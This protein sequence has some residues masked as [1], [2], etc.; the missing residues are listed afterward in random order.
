VNNIRNQQ[1]IYFHDKFEKHLAIESNSSDNLHP[2]TN[3]QLWI[4]FLVDAREW[5][6]SFTC[7]SLLPV[8][9]TE[10][11]ILFNQRY[12]EIIDEALTPLWARFHFHLSLTRESVVFTSSDTNLQSSDS[13]L[14]SSD[15]NLQSSVPLPSHT[16]EQLLW[17]FQYARNYI[18]MVI[19]LSDEINVS[20]FLQ[21]LHPNDYK[22]VA[23]KYIIEKSIRI[24]RAHI[25][26][27]FV[28]YFSK[29]TDEFIKIFVEQIFNLDSYLNTWESYQTINICRV[30][31][32][33]KPFHSRWLLIERTQWI[34]LL[35]PYFKNIKDTY[36]FEFGVDL[37]VLDITP[38][39]RDMSNITTT[40]NESTNKTAGVTELKCYKGIYHTM[41]FFILATQRY[42]YLPKESQDIVSAIILEP[43]L[44]LCV[45]M[46]LFKTKIDPSLYAISNK[47]SYSLSELA[48]SEMINKYKRN[49]TYPMELQNFLSSVQYVQKC[50][51]HAS[52]PSLFISNRDRYEDTWKIL[53]EWI[54]KRAIFDHEYRP[55]GLFSP[56]K[57]LQAS[58]DTITW[59]DYFESKSS[60]VI[61]SLLKKN[62]G[63]LKDND[64]HG[65][66]HHHVH[67]LMGDN[68]ELARAQMLTLSRV[69]EKQFQNNVLKL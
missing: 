9:L 49:R 10:S 59:K 61:S 5:L 60:S 20:D 30:L 23:R 4:N 11:K 52:Y 21:K 57:L 65:S 47:S 55:N 36:S 53:V 66:S 44:S 6:L 12:E 37:N 58:L 14:Q 22:K 31:Y 51:K 48:S 8:V 45:G 54:P 62:K 7:I 3:L 29:F 27:V 50:L 25:A 33:A 34:D 2:G 28:K 24:M 16:L 18:D 19:N 68:I 41:K 13:N 35:K 42:Q 56:L 38:L 43:L 17:A 69:L 26:D 67:G 15:N 1:I 40:V 46:F 39:S 63:N 32:D 64:I